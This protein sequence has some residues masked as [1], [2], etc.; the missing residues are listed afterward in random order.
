MFNRSVIRILYEIR[1]GIIMKIR[2]LIDLFIRFFFFVIG[3]LMRIS[4]KM[5]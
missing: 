1:K 2:D 5:I 3:F 4:C